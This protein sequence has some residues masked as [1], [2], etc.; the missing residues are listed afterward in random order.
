MLSR[1]GE[2]TIDEGVVV[3]YCGLLPEFAVE[4]SLVA[5]EAGGVSS[6]IPILRVEYPKN[7]TPKPSDRVTEDKLKKS[8]QDDSV[9]SYRL[10]SP[11]L[12]IQLATT[13]ACTW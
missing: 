10:L 6:G 5:G 13:A 8:R 9:K 2:C 7:Y 1:A 3:G 4:V 12:R 11:A